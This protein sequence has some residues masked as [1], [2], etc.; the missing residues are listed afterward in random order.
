V[1]RTGIMV[2]NQRQVDISK[3]QRTVILIENCNQINFKGAA[4]RNIIKNII[5]SIRRFFQ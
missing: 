3:L 4:H 5:K 1:H 2:E